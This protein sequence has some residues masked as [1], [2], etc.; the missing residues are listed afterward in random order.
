MAYRR[1][2]V[3]VTQEFAGLTPALAAF[4]LPSVVVGPAYQLVD[5][6]V[7][8]NYAGTEAEY[9]YASAEGGFIVDTAKLAD[10]EAFPITKKPVSALLK[11]AVVEI[12]ALQQDGSANGTSFTD[13]TPSSFNDV[14]A[15]DLIVITP[16]TGVTIVA[17]QTNGAS[18]D[19][20]GQRNR[21]TAGTA[22]QFVNVKQGDSVI[23]TAGTN[24]VNGT[25]SVVAKPS[26]SILVLSG[27][28]NDGIGPSTDV[29]FSITGDRGQANAGTWKVKTKTS[30][31]A[32]VIESS[33]PEVEAPLTYSI[34]RKVGTIALSR[35]DSLSGNGF[36]VSAGNIAL[37]SGLTHEI[38]GSDFDVISGS[39]EASYRALRADLAAEVR[40]FSRTADLT[41][42]F[43]TGQIH[44]A[45]PLAYGLS[46]MMQN[47]VTPVNGLGLD[48]NGQADEV[49]SFTSAADVLKTVDMY[50]IALLS[51]SPVV[52]TLF[53]NHV[54]QLSAPNKK[55]ERVVLINSTL[56]TT[57][58]LQTEKTT[59]TS[60]AGARSIVTTQVDGSGAVANP[61]TLIDAT[62][63]QFA[64]VNVGDSVV[65]VSGTGVTPGTYTVITKTD[66]NTLILSSPFI[67]SGTPTNITYYIV[68]QDGIN[69]AGLSLYDRN[70]EF[71]SNGVAPGHFIN[72]LSGANK[73]RYKIATV[74]SEKQVTLSAALA[75]VITLQTAVNYRADRNLSKNEQATA[76]KGYGESFAS[77]R[78]VHCWP[79][80]V[81]APIGQTTEDLPGYYLCCT[82]AALTTGL[83]TQQGLTNLSVSGF[84]G[85]KNSTKYFDEDQLDIIAE[86][87]SMIFGQDGEEQPL[88]IRHQLTTDRSAIKFQEYS[89]TKNVDYVAKFIRNTFAPFIGQ[90]NI[91]D[92][93]LDALKT[94]AEGVIINLRDNQRVAKFGG[95]IRGGKLAS[96][97]ESLTQI[98]TVEM[99][100]QFQMPIPLNNLEITIEV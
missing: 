74:D 68:R 1:P 58:I 78:V 14:L 42:V 47:T 52:H 20:A 31:T 62:S 50:A 46:V 90:Y 88:F 18:S 38:G 65:V 85:F 16:A 76:V 93:T 2:G 80:V 56:K 41:S 67:T 94:T 9:A 25:F 79:D 36:V 60:T 69:A 53:K 17:A 57:A 95:V 70:A 82:V 8:G 99:R 10:D 5:N 7:L 43:G 22:N 24:T 86:G 63:A 27:D 6:D 91:I 54:E 26:D 44:P 72:I 15:G 29:S 59:S 75:G 77:R 71:I 51:H 34:R 66:A 97:V 100:F 30:A 49:L 64:S 37:P 21:L 40:S 92:T 28:I 48:A 19:T 32:L 87:G 12:V 13:A 3:T 23:V 39:L 98:D 4:T 73:G 61:E 83:P 35:V 89:V 33:F 11:N 84:L 81:K 96:V 45:N 55:L